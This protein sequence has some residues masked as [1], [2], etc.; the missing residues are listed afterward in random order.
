MHQISIPL[1]CI[2]IEYFTL[3]VILR[4]LLKFHLKK[5]VNQ[6][7]LGPDQY[8]QLIPKTVLNTVQ[9]YTKYLCEIV[10]LVLVVIRDQ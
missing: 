8:F 5:L 3:K 4:Y 10:F 9:L 2:M 7:L 1:D 6:S